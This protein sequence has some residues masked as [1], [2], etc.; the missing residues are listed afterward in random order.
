MRTIIVGMLIIAMLLD[1]PRYSARLSD[2]GLV[3]VCPQ[4]RYSCAADDGDRPPCGWE[5]ERRY[6]GVRR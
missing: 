2:V 4:L 6:E 5:T 1:L 3:L